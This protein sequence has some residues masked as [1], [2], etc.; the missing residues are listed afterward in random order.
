M[1]PPVEAGQY[2]SVLYSERLAEHVIAPSV[3]S[4]GDSYDNAMAE[5]G[6]GLYKT[7]LIRRRGPWRKVDQV[8]IE[9]LEYV[10][11]FNYRRL[12]GEIGHVPPAEFEDMF[13]ASRQEAG[14]EG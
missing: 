13:Y 1:R 10:D 9:T 6:I 4:V 11:W 5:S 8:E 7:E 14:I 12:H 2:T 3:G